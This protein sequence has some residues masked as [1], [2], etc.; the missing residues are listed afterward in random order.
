MS[1]IPTVTAGAVLATSADTPE[2]EALICRGFDFH[3]YLFESSSSPIT[4]NESSS[5][6][7]QQAPLLDAILSSMKTSGFQGTN[8]GLAIEQIQSM[9]AWRLSHVSEVKDGDP[10]HRDKIRA[11]I[12]LAYTSNQIS[13]GQREVLRFLV[14]HSM[15]DVIVTSAGGIEE[16]LIKCM[17]NTYLGDFH[18][19]GKD[20]RKRGMNRIGNLL[21]PN[22]NYVVFEEWM[23]PIIQKMHQ[24]QMES[25]K[26]WALEVAS[27]M[28]K[29]K[30]RTTNKQGGDDFFFLP[31]RFVWS[32][33]KII[34]RLG[35]EINNEDSLLYWAAKNNI[36]IFCPA[37][38]DGSIGDMF[39]FHSYKENGFVM[40][41][42]QD[43]RHLNDLALQS[44]CTGQIILGGSTPKHH[45]NNAN[46]MRNGA[47]YSVY[48]NTGQEFDGSD[49]GASPDEAVSW[50][51]IRLTANP[52]KVCADATIVWPLIVS[53]T[54]AK[55]VQQW[56][57]E[58]KDC[59]CWIYDDNE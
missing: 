35:L 40:D 8:L 14:Q 22:R 4:P 19:A 42:N 36:P 6:L 46:L 13:S 24:E 59:V 1:H 33:S 47:D 34:R 41:I 55:N 5:S 29:N 37:L 11:R 27:L 51:K 43:I 53:Q 48:I 18:L 52:V 44:Y 26:A 49:S 9:R 20:L 15:V 50:G 25:D 2:E 58:T 57:E 56:K 45:T 23:T 32:P 31:E 3:K 10:I 54:F 7:Q 39:Y 17:A 28:E 30:N 12:F 38:T 16:D 21:I